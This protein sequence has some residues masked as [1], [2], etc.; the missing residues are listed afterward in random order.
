MSLLAILFLSYSLVL[1]QGSQPLPEAPALGAHA[2]KTNPDSNGVYH[3]EKGVVSAPELTLSVEPEYPKEARKH[4][5]EGSTRLRIVVDADG[6]VR[7]ARVIRSAVESRTKQTDRE[8]AS[9]F[10]T[11][12]IET[13]KQYRF[14]PGLLKDHPVRVEIEI[15]VEFRM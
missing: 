7:D 10:D 14:K 13:V 11:A 8:T 12:A 6:H 5:L 1:Q 9:L 15:E 4:R 3:V 2:P